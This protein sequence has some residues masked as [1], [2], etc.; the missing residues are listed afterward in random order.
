MKH[1][2]KVN[3]LDAVGHF[4]RSGGSSASKQGIVN[5]ATR[6][7]T[8]NAPEGEGQ[9]EEEDSSKLTLSAVLLSTYCEFLKLMG[10]ISA[11][12]GTTAGEHEKKLCGW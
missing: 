6:A 5:T 1:R 8:D 12:I 11:S 3:K 7:E 2:K 10:H 4:R 9:E